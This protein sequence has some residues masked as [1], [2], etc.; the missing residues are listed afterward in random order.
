ME[1]YR[2]VVRSYDQTNHTAN[3]LL[4]GSM[5][6]VVLA[7]P[8]SHQIG[9]ELM[10]EGADCGV[11]F[12]AEGAAG[13]VICTFDGAPGA[14]VTPQ[15]LTFSPA[16]PEFVMLS[17]GTDQAV[18]N[19]W[20]TY[21][22]LSQQISV[23]SGKTYSVLAIGSV[24]FECTSYANWNID[25]ARI[26]S[27]A[28]GLGQPQSLRMNAENERGAVPV[29]GVEKITSSTTYSVKIY[30]SMDRNTEVCHRGNL[31]LIWWEDT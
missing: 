24:E 25:V 16:T 5:S 12:F 13:V 7:V 23:P 20:Q 22:T 2:G 4:V 1:F 14:W 11:L 3:V 29:L 19:S 21:D 30:K 27:G 8:V 6:R 10:A 9:S 15:E 18:T 26:Y 31:A 28:T 17:T